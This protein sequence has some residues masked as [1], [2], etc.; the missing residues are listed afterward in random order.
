MKDEIPSSGSHGGMETADPKPTRC[1]DSE[2]RW[3][4]SRPLD[5][6]SASAPPDKAPN[7]PR[8][9]KSEMRAIAKAI[10]N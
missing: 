7:L 8:V 2:Y 4:S 3:S 9:D 10:R 5:G 6:E 1:H